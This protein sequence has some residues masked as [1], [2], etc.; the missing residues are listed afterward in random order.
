M[1]LASL[2]QT[3]VATALPTIVGDL[4]GLQHLSWVVTAYLLASTI[5]GAALRQARRPLRPQDR[6]CRSRSSSSSSARRSA[7]SRRTCRELIAF[8]ARAG[9]R[10]R[11]P[12]RRRR[13]PSS[14]TSSRRATAAGTRASS[15]RSSASSTIVGPLL[16]G[17][18]VDNLSW[19]W[20]F[21]VNL[22]IGAVAL[23]VIGAVFHTRTERVEHAIDYLGAALL[24]AALTCDRAL[25]EPR[26]HDVR[27]G[28]AG[29]RRADRRSAS[30]LLVGVRASPSGARRSRSC[31]SSSSGT[32]SSPCARAIG[33]IIGF[34]LF[35]SVTY[36]PL[37]LQIVK[38]RSPTTSG[39]QLTPMMARPARHVD[40]QRPADQQVR[41]LQAVPGRRHRGDDRRHGAALAARHRTR[42]PA[43]TSLYMLVLGLGLGMVMQVLV[44]AVQNAVDYR[45]MGVATSG[46]LALPPDR[47]LDRH[48]DL[49]RD[50]REP[51]A[52]RARVDAAC[53]RAPAEDRQPGGRRGTC[54]RR[55]H[56]AYVHAVAAALHPVFVVAAV[57][58]GLRLR[59]HVAP[60]RGAAA[61]L[62][63]AARRRGARAASPQPTASSPFDASDAEIVELERPRRLAALAQREPRERAA[64][65]GSSP[66]RSRP[67]KP[68]VDYDAAVE[69]ALCFGWVDSKSRTRRRRAD[70]ALL[71]AAQAEELVVGV[72]RRARREARSG[73]AD[74]RGRPP[75]GRGGEAE[76]PVA[77]LTKCSESPFRANRTDPAFPAT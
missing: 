4:G 48:R 7:G 42:R 33:F 13:S 9:P 30:S 45:N 16:G 63:A 18:F 68:R 52:R 22:P 11:R 62:D 51:A 49:R 64:A 43:Y 37:F 55:V 12:D 25:H 53:R 46:S 1:L 20:I 67:G 77:G 76:R 3:I 65:S 58:R 32:A 73:R 24:A 75:G 54:R 10:R 31:R 50:L 29:D 5:T 34:A 71:H 47:R 2:D 6:R 60:A 36:L 15:A 14:A 39:L 17:F 56:D 72:E 44:L 59:A 19:R 21:Y 70:L 66:G 27:V 38:G 23:V 40:R 35:G 8:R 57:D 69:E 61:R 74:A 26:R 28:L 41:A